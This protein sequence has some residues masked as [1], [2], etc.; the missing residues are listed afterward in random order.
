MMRGR[1]SKRR[2]AFVIQDVLELNKVDNETITQAVTVW[3][4]DLVPKSE[5]HS[6]QEVWLK[7]LFW[8]SLDIFV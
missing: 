7:Q 1:G 5:S 8:S 2:V 4:L 6:Q 3:K